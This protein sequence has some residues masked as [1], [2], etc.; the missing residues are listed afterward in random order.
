[1]VVISQN[2][3]YS[4]HMHATGESNEWETCTVYSSAS[5]SS[6]FKALSSIYLAQG[7]I[8]SNKIKYIHIHVCLKKPS[9]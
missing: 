5:V 7:R 3:Y 4:M 1:M 6:D 9:S 2:K 8:K